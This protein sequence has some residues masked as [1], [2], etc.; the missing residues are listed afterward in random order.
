MQQCANQG[1]ASV[2][3]QQAEAEG[4]SSVDIANLQYACR[5]S[6][7]MAKKF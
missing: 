7:E 6:E 3:W 2:N 1:Y 5:N 4:I